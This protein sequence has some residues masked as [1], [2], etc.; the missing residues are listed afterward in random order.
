MSHLQ[1]LVLKHVRE[2]DE[3]TQLFEDLE[4]QF[5]LNELNNKFY[6]FLKLIS[7]KMK[8]FG[9]KIQD[10]ID[11]F[12]D[13]ENLGEEISDEQ[14]AHHVLSLLHAFHQSLSQVLL[15][16]DRQTITYNEVVNALLTENVYQKMMIL[17]T[18]FSFFNTTL[19]VI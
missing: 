17:S 4:L 15:H 18:P 5:H 16:C 8:D 9:A 14:K 6:V 3:F 2:N 7:F 19:N 11:A 13:L 10:H 12:S 1:P